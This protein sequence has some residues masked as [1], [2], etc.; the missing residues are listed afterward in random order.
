MDNQT[1]FW[2]GQKKINGGLCRV[3]WSLVEALKA[4]SAALAQLA[5]SQPAPSD[6]VA[7]LDLSALNHWIAEADRI[8]AGVADIIPPGCLPRD[9]TG[10]DS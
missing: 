6:Q 4:V 3:D 8:S 9:R 7:A 10:G 2:E 1:D 5:A